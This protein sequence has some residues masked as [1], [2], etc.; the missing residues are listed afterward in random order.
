FFDKVAEKNKVDR[1][2]GNETPR[3]CLDQREEKLDRRAGGRGDETP[4]FHLEKLESVLSEDSEEGKLQNAPPQDESNALIG[5]V[6]QVVQPVV[7]AM[8]NIAAGVFLDEGKGLKQRESST[9]LEV[10]PARRNLFPPAAR[11]SGSALNED[12]ATSENLQSGANKMSG[13]GALAQ[14]PETSLE[15]QTTAKPRPLL[16]KKKMLQLPPV[17]NKTFFDDVCA[18]P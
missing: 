16:P 13:A 1:S 9:S 3:F 14:R 12:E 15:H 5:P 2:A 18:A 6:L 17:V 4:R 10:E 11:K 8:N 7:A